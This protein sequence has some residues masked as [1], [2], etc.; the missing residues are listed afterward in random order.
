MRKNL[1]KKKSLN[2]VYVL[3]LSKQSAI[4]ISA[5]EIEENLT[6]P[7]HFQCKLEY[8]QIPSEK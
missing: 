8:F 7:A 5:V 2:F 3:I 6:I 4:P 1:K